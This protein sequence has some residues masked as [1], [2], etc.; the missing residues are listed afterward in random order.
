MNIGVFDSGL[1]GLAI[2]KEIIARLP[3]YNYL[4]LGDNARV[5]YGNRS[6]KII[7]EFTREAVEFLLHEGATLVILAC[8]TATTNA[9][10]KLQRDYL[11][12]R[13]PDRRVLGV[14]KPA[15]ETVAEG[16]FRRV[17]VIGTHATV[18]SRAFVREIKK[19]LPATTVYQRACPL[20]VPIIEEGR[21]DWRGLDLEL[22]ECLRPLLSKRIDSLIL[23]CTHYGLIEEK[24][25]AWVG[26]GVTVVS[27]GP[28]VAEK[29]DSYLEKHPEIKKGLKKGRQRRFYV[30]DR[31]RQYE[32]LTRLFLGPHFQFGDKLELVDIA[33]R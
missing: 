24:I 8:N 10:R 28:A 33:G 19:V 12:K 18:N 23:G 16:G 27:E 32:K 17:G 14:V 11:P 25:K 20:L 30:T 15:V 21:L 4:Y 2:L 5:P 6:P 3:D 9:L 31:T 7:Y 1:G 26:P 22:E 29:L 13:Y